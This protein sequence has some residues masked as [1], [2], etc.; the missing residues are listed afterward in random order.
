VTSRRPLPARSLLA[1]GL[2]G[3]LLA[4]AAC[5]SP[6]ASPAPK[7][8]AAARQARLGE[9]AYLTGRL[10]EAIRALREAVRLH[11]SAGDVPG[12]GRSL[13][14]LA[15]AQRAAGQPAGA[16]GT[17]AL[18]LQLAPAADQQARER[19]A[20]GEAMIASAWLTALLAVDR[21]EPA[22]AAGAL[23]ALP[24]GPYAPLWTGRI[25]NV[26]AD[27]ALASGRPAEAL[28]HARAG[29]PASAAAGD[30]AEEARALR[31]AGTARLGLGQWTEARAEFLAAV[32]LEESLGGGA[33]M[34]GD[35][36]H[37]AEIAE[38]QGDAP[39]AR[40]YTARAD[41]LTGKKP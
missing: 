11:L 7:L 3:L 12:A 6:Q 22:A 29:R 25:E 33:R 14:N 24:P 34:A 23:A 5:S 19:G 4:L 8:R 1:A 41:L 9:E 26:R 40:L 32:R 37:L 38:H 18:L 16:L 31:L 39:A 2:A 28:D 27:L 35:L 15:L 13:V 17:A 20:A 21:G 36:Y 10:D 30:R